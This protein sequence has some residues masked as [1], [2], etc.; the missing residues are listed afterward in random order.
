MLMLINLSILSNEQLKDLFLRESKR[1][2][3]G[4]DRGL[5]FLDLKQI[6]IN[7][8]EITVEQLIRKSHFLDGF[9][10]AGI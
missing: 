6:R 3:E 1:F 10:P 2:R 7:L 8:R 9:V 4:I 5:H